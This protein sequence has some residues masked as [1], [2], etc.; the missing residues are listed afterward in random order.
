MVRHRIEEVYGIKAQTLFP[1]FSPEVAH[2]PQDPL[3]ELAGWAGPDGDDGGHF[4]VVS[5]LQPYK[6]VDR[7]I[8][9][10]REMPGKRLLV[11]GRG[12]ERERLTAIAPPNVRLVEGIT[13]AQLR[14]AYGHA[15]A[16]IAASH[17]DFGL[18]PLEAGAHGVPTLALRAG[19]Y[20]DTVRDGANGLF[21]DTPRPPEIVA[22]VRRSE[23]TGWDPDTVRD[24]ARTFSEE[25]FLNELRREVNDG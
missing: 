5:R 21:F 19:G 17:E 2:G 8:E 25:R 22:A 24:V 20:R 13:D 7:V 3:P 6:H 23:L 4:L 10:F 16:L 11:V 12:P 1:P 18:T 14:W 15:V 9:A